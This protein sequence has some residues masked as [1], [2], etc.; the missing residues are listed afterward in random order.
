MSETVVKF[1]LGEDNSKA[2]HTTRVRYSN[3]ALLSHRCTRACPIDMLINVIGHGFGIIQIPLRDVSCY[4]FCPKNNRKSAPLTV[5]CLVALSK[6]EVTGLAVHIFKLN[7]GAEAMERFAAQFDK[8]TK[9]LFE[10]SKP[11]DDVGDADRLM[12]FE[13]MIKDTAD[14]STPTSADISIAAEPAP[15]RKVS[16]V[17]EET[18]VILEEYVPPTRSACSDTP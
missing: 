9:A 4:V 18:V 1:L 2:D 3:N 16:H 17:G 13:E 12:S 7:G 15:V 14:P 5:V 10:A 11:K 6:K 8:T